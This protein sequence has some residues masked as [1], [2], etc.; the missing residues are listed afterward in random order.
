MANL[1]MR[2][3]AKR[4][5]HRARLEACLLAD[6]DIGL[7][8]IE[9]VRVQCSSNQIQL[10]QQPGSLAETH[11]LTHDQEVRLSE[12]LQEDFAKLH[13]HIRKAKLLTRAAESTSILA[14]LSLT[15]SH[16]LVK[17]IRKVRDQLQQLITRIRDLVQDKVIDA[18]LGCVKVG[19]DRKS[20]ERASEKVGI[21]AYEN[22]E[23]IVV[24]DAEP[25]VLGTLATEMT[26]NAFELEVYDC[27]EGIPLAHAAI[28]LT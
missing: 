25:I 13:K 8:R 5:A 16:L 15:F 3:T 26:Q 2:S 19:I 9:I 21:Y 10:L 22:L 11:G 17:Q 6:L 14:P 24:V 27:L 28:E 23:V 20:F 18:A 1:E 7:E 4:A 12:T